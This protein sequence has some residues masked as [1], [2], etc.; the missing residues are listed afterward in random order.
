[1]PR[2]ALLKE[3]EEVNRLIAQ[4]EQDKLR[5]QSRVDLAAQ[6]GSLGSDGER[7]APRCGKSTRVG[8]STTGILATGGV[9]LREEEYS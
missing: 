6:D 7:G 8:S 5:Q 1:M 9:P 3:L 2:D 4:E